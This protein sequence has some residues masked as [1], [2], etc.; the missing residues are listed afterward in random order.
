MAIAPLQLLPSPAP[1]EGQGV[2][3]FP[4]GPPFATLHTLSPLRPFLPFSPPPNP[5]PFCTFHFSLFTFHSPPTPIDVP[6][7]PRTLDG[8]N[9][10]PSGLR[11]FIAASP[12]SPRGI[13]RSHAPRG[14]ATDGR[15]G[16]LPE[17]RRGAS[18]DGR[19]G[20]TA[21][22]LASLSIHRPTG[23]GR[24]RFLRVD[25]RSFRGLT[26][27]AA[28]GRRPFTGDAPPPRM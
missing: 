27:S 5:F 3:A 18:D 1:G 6:M 8:R 23:A 26:G 22:N 9:T 12:S 15:S 11:R 20:Q 14:N 21:Q 17:G 7:S 10:G 19:I 4:Q 16:P 13:P 2:R 24:E 28:I 25:P